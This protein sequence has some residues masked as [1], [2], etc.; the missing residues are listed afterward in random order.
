MALSAAGP[1]FETITIQGHGHDD[2]VA[3]VEHDLRDLDYDDLDF[4]RKRAD[5]LD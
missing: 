5:L 3:E 1:R 4:A 2:E